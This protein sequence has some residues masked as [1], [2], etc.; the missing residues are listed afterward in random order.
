M[1]WNNLFILAVPALLVAC[2]NQ[3]G[4]EAVVSGG[5]DNARVVPVAQ[6]GSSDSANQGAFTIDYLIGKFDPAKH[7]DFVEIAPEHASRAGMYLRRDAYEAFK[8]MYA[9]ARQ[10]GIRLTIISATRNFDYQKGIWEAKWT[11]A[12]LIEDG[13]NLAQTTP[14]PVERALKILRYSAMP[15]S[16]RH[17]WGT[18]MDLN[19]LNNPFFD[20]GE[21][22]KIYDWLRAHAAS[23]GFCQP[24][25]PKGPGRPDGYNEE[26]WHWSYLP[27]ARPLTDLARTQLK[28]ELI[29]G[30]KGSETASRIGV[31]EKYV[32][33]VNE[34]CR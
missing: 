22:K 10:D 16:S 4:R 6:S 15:G 18:D 27:V 9:A 3:K 19:N 30:F 26:R 7:P 20:N 34:E 1:Q 13:E 8:K 11:G 21:G 28:D 29:T 33:G 25:S 23:F 5:E 2:Q 17:H 14:D 32:L 24:Y 12:R 31:V